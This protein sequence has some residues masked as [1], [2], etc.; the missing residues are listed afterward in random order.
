MQSL[1]SLSKMINNL[2]EFLDETYDINC[3]GCC[4]LAYLLAVNLEKLNIK[5]SLVVYDT[6]KKDV[7]Q[8]RITSQKKYIST[9]PE[10]II[11]GKGTCNHYCILLEKS[12]YLN[13]L[14]PIDGYEY[15]ITGI[16]SSILK[17]I[18]KKGKW[19]SYYKRNKNRVIKNIVYNFFKK[20]EK[21]TLLNI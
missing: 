1:E 20:Y 11:T 17:W 2:C 16:N 12:L 18:Y 21:E 15:I 5:Y 7:N 13:N 8:V 9:I 19:N 14:Y 6:F 10:F 4:Y 3:G